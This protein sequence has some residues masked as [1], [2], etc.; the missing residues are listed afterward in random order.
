[1]KERGVKNKKWELKKKMS[2]LYS[3]KPVILILL[4]TMILSFLTPAISSAQ[5]FTAEQS[6]EE[7][8]SKANQFVYLDHTSEKFKV[9]KEAASVLTK[10]EL[11]EVE[12]IIKDTN[13]EVSKYRSDLVIEGN[14]FGAKITETSS[15]EF[16]ATSDINRSNNFDW[17]FTWWGLQ[18]YWSHKFV[19]KLKSN[20]LLLGA[21][22]AA[23][24]ATIAYYLTPPG[25]VT[26]FVTAVVGIG[27]WSFISRDKG[28]GVLLDCYVYVPT[29]WYSAC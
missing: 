27:V 13:K 2:T 21:G 28:C 3:K 4:F 12:A 5:S 15:G 19:E 20:I 7:L 18:V 11:K 24:N 6:K 16:Q 14:K 22:T 26:S 1:L 8:V 9:M 25:W 23:M 17:D 10:E 29:Y